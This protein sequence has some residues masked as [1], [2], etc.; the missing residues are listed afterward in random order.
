M[1]RSRKPRRLFFPAIA[2]MAVPFGAW[3]DSPPA[4]TG[5][6]SGIW[7]IQDENASISTTSQTD[8]YYVNGINVGWTSLPGV[9]P[10]PLADLGHAVWGNGTQRI[11]IGII[12]QLY[13]PADTAAI[14]PPKNDEPYAGYLAGTLN[15]IQDTATTRSVLGVDV[16]V[17][18]RDAGGEI[19]QNDFHSIIGQKGTHGWAYQLPSEPAVDFLVSR[20][21]RLPLAHFG[22][23]MEAD[24]LP[25][26]SGMAGLTQDYVQSAVGFRFG[27]GLDSDFGPPL[28]APSPS[29]SDAFEATRP[30]VWY[31]FGSAAGKVVAHDEFLQ[32]SDFQ[33]SRGVDPNVVVGTFEAGV[34]VIW[35]G[36]RFTY[37]Q[38]FQTNTFL[39]EQ[40][41]I[42]EFGSFSAGFSF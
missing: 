37:T 25:Q 23:G 42:H 36:V 40:G 34:T 14:N 29:G 20:T 19:V 41:S 33:S 17:I 1:T 28:L 16:G 39:G 22:N 13:T 21:W 27:Q 10:K 7:T 31:V 8:R 12:Q 38:A 32:G 4:T 26:L 18:G 2:M 11:N 30:L 35:R 6:P 9:V 3:A 5:F 24:V 15:L